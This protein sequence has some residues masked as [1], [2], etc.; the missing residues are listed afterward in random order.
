[1]QLAPS[2]SKQ[3][4]DV[5]KPGNPVIADREPARVVAAQVSSEGGGEP[6]Q[7][8]P[9]ADARVEEA[10][11]ATVDFPVTLSRASTSTVAVDCATPNGTATAGSDYTA[12]SGTLTFAPRETRK[13]IA[14]AVLDDMRVM[15]DEARTHATSA[16]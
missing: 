4:D 6:L 5:E 15:D 2:R 13:T 14:V 10:D 8:P 7:Q 16:L 9:M 11:S 1:M 12:A 3:V